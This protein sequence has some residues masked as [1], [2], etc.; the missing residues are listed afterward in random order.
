MLC[1]NTGKKTF[2]FQTGSIRRDYFTT[3]NHVLD[4]F[5]FQTGSIRR[6]ER[7]R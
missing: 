1:V 4:G 7:M 2:L 3:A 6:V 5:L